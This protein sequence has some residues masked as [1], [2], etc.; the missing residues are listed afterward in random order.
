M[1]K[2]ISQ[3]ELE[4]QA[5][6]PRTVYNPMDRDFTHTWDKVSYIIPAGKSVILPGYLAHHMAKHLAEYIMIHGYG[7]LNDTVL[8]DGKVKPNS[9]SRG[10]L[11]K[12][13]A[14]ELLDKGDVEAFSVLSEEGMPTEDV[15][16]DSILGSLKKDKKA[17]K[18]AKAVKKPAKKEVP[19]EEPS[20]ELEEVPTEESSDV[21]E[22]E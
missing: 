12:F 9:M 8:P 18:E 20:E 16:K 15:D 3:V 22:N 19:V 7:R 21:P 13:M 2:D 6:T 14:E 4:R 5:N 1:A 10:E 11:E 17:A